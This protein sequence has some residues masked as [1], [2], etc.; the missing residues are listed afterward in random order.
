MSSPACRN[1]ASTALSDAM[2][3]GLDSL[4]A[5]AWASATNASRAAWTPASSKAVAVE[6]SALAV[7]SSSWSR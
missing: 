4:A 1:E 7:P 2:G 3:L 6:G 5:S